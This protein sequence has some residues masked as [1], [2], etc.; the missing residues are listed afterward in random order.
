MNVELATDDAVVSIQR[1][2]DGGGNPAPDGRLTVVVGNGRLLSLSLMEAALLHEALRRVTGLPT[3]S[4]AEHA[5]MD[6]VCSALDLPASWSRL[7]LPALTARLR[8]SVSATVVAG[9]SDA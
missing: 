8:E 2:H 3:P 4:E 5:A 1:D 7:N 9:D 6:E